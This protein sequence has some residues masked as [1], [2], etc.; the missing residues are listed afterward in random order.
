MR[1]HP[2]RTVL[3]VG[4][5]P[6]SK[7]LLDHL[8]AVPPDDYVVVNDHPRRQ[9]PIHRVTKRFRLPVAAFCETLRDLVEDAGDATWLAGWQDASGHVGRAPR[10]GILTG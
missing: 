9:D 10:R 2:V 3:H 4:G 6:T 1:R 8:D 7:R 5:R